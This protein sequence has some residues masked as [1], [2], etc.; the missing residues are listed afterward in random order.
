MPLGDQ[1]WDKERIWAALA[2]QHE[3]ILHLEKWRERL[4]Q[5]SFKLI[6]I[7]VGGVISLVVTVA[8]A[9]VLMNLGM[10]NGG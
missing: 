1:G 9:V 10:G 4:E 7:V 8:G 3:R 6:L 5:R 2:S